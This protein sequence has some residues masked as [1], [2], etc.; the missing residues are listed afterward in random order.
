MRSILAGAVAM[1]VAGMATPAAAAVVWHTSRAAF[2]AAA[3]SSVDPTGMSGVTTD[4]QAITLMETSPSVWRNTTAEDQ[5]DITLGRVTISQGIQGPITS[6]GFSMNIDGGTPGSAVGFTGA[7]YRIGNPLDE[8]HSY[9][10]DG[11]GAFAFGFNIYE[12]RS[13]SQCGNV[14]CVISRFTFEAF[15]ASG[16]SLGTRVYDFGAQAETAFIGIVSTTA[17]TRLTVTESQLSTGCCR[18]DNEYF[19]NYLM[20]AANATSG[21]PE[22]A[23]W[24]M[25]LL[26]FGAIGFAL[27][28]NRPHVTARIRFA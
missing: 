3:P 21:V 18:Y 13:G 7:S 28:R 16:A 23:T 26:G 17:F 1:T 8:N 22:P 2:I 5:Y 14:P 27:R 12:P 20:T 4:A 15:D 11:T 24:A 9:T 10:I 6:H 25:M 19:G